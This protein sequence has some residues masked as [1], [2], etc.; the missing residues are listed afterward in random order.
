MEIKFYIDSELKRTKNTN[1]IA[2]TF[3]SDVSIYISD[4]DYGDHILTAQAKSDNQL[5]NIDSV[6]NENDKNGLTVK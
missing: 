3:D 4:L 2:R 6:V 1:P 5:T